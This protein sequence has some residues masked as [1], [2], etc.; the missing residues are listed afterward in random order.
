MIDTIN[1][2][3]NEPKKPHSTP[4]NQAEGAHD[5]E[6]TAHASKEAWVT[7]IYFTDFVVQ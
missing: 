7:N 5:E 3:L 1:D 6:E 4:E 2:L